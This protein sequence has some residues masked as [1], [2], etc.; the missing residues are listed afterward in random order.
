MKIIVPIIAVGV[1][2]ASCSA[3]KQATTTQKQ[4]DQLAQL[5]KSGVT[6]YAFGAAPFWNAEWTNEAVKY[7][8][9]YN[10]S[11]TLENKLG[12]PSDS[13]PSITKYKIPSGDFSI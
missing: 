10:L 3:K 12:L 6:F 5:Y 13:T 2:L 1:L 7:E 11:F 8:G 9:R 4:P